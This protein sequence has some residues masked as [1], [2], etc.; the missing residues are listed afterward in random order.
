MERP[1]RELLWGL[2]FGL[3]AAVC[4]ALGAVLSRKA[5]AAARFAGENI[6]GITAA[7]QRILGGVALGAVFLLFVKHGSIFK[8]SSS[9]RRAEDIPS[10]LS[11]TSRW[12]Q[13]WPWVLANGLAGPALG[14]SCYQW[15][16]KTTPTGVVLP[17]VAI[18]PLVIIPFSHHIEGERPT[19]RSL[20]GGALAVAGAVALAWTLHQPK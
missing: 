6:D 1:R 5:F 16:L 19:A 14:V 10:S 3:L 4:Q 15:A 18:T 8:T 20:A 12:R 9:E 7:Y 11:R 13:A 2:S 17:I